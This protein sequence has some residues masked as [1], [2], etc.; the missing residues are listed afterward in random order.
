MQQGGGIGY[1]F[2]TL[3]PKGAPVKGVGADA[4]GPLSLH[5]CVGRDVPHHH[6]RRLSP[7]RDDGDACAATIPTSRPSSRPSASPA[8]C[9]CST[10]RCWSPTPSCRRCKEDAPWE[11]KFAG[12]TYKVAAGARAVGQDHARDLCLCRAGRDLHRPHQ[13]PQQSRTI[14]RPSARPTRAASSRCRLMA[15]ACWARSISRRWCAIPSRRRRSSTWTS[16]RGSCRWRCACSTTPSTCRA[17]RSPQQTHEAQAKRRIGLGVTGLADA[18]ILCGVRYGSAEA[19]ALTE[20]WLQRDRARGL[21]RLGASSPPRKA[22][23]R[24][25]TATHYLAGE[26]VAGARCRCARRHRRARHPQ[27][28]PHL[29]GADRHDLA[30]RRQRLLRPRAGVQLQLHAQ[31]AD[32]RRHA[33]ARRRSSDYAYRLFRRLKGEGAPLPDYFV[34]A[35]SLAPADHLVMQAAVQKYVDSSISKTINVPADFPFEQLQGRLSP[36]LRAGLQGLHHLPPERGD[37][38]G[39][40]GEEGRRQAPGAPGRAAAAGAARRK[41]RRHLRGGRRRLHDAAARPARGA[42]RQ[43]PTRSAGP[44]ASTRSTS[45]STTSCRTAAAARSRSSSTRRTWSITPGPWR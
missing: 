12:T 24:C 11:L 18:L 25:S 39:A 1:D 15:R 14:A 16:S 17:S 40:A 31:R 38:R 43:A 34:D 44:K 19:V 41:P 10:S 21:S 4:S 6:E 8:G 23:S 3:R 9:A 7:R 36:G 29:G 27:R 32:A 30:L 45:P 2:S 26:T 5:G 28:A 22:R 33:H 13:P 20:H 35:Q 42:A 37:G